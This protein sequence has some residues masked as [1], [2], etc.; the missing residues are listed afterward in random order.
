MSTA[1]KYLHSL[2]AYLVVI[3][4]IITVGNALIS[5]VRKRAFTAKD[6]RIPLF[7]LIA[8]HLQILI[9]LVLFFISPMIRWFSSGDKG[10]IMKDSTLRL[11]NVE[12]PLIMII[13]VILITIGFSR[14]KKKVSSASKFKI[15]LVFYGIALLLILSRIPWQAWI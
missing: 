12:H 1:I 10:M 4:I 8:T 9:G 15:I 2:W 13:A 14:H 6:L 11:Y 5:L 3:M 7:A